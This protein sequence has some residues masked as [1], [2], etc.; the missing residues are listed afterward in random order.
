M[1][2]WARPSWPASP[3]RSCATSPPATRRSPSWCQP[4]AWPA[5]PAWRPSSA[6]RATTSRGIDRE[7]AQADWRARAAEHGFGRAELDRSRPRRR[8]SAVPARRSR[9]APAPAWPARPGLT[10]SDSTFNRRAV[11]RAVAE[12]HRERHARAALEDLADAFIAH[13]GVAVEPARA[14]RGIRE[15]YTMADMLRAEAR[16]LAS[17]TSAASGAALSTR[18]PSPQALAAQRTLGADQ[19]AARAP[20]GGRRRARAC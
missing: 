10:K 1:E 15:T 16:L 2:Q 7:P 17:P 6:R 18:A 9:A 11:V 12:A 3:R 4:G 19:R 13:H 20:P 14:R 8:R 5:S